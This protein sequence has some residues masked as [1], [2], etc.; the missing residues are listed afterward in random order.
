MRWSVPD[1][2]HNP[3]RWVELEKLMSGSLCNEFPCVLNETHEEN[4]SNPKGIQ[5]LYVGAIYCGIVKR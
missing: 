3:L 2:R 1:I 4:R 5:L